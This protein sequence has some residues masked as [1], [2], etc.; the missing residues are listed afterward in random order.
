MAKSSIS[1]V[2]VQKD[3]MRVSSTDFMSFAFLSPGGSRRFDPSGNDRLRP[4]SETDK[5]RMRFEK[6]AAERRRLHDEAKNYFPQRRL[7]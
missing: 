6:G 5:G 2:S 4:L 7:P 1:L 3:V